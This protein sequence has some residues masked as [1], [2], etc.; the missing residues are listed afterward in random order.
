MKLTVKGE[1]RGKQRPRFNMRTGSTYTPSETVAY[2]KAIRAAYYEAGGNE[3][4]KCHGAAALLIKAYYGIPKTAPKSAKDMMLQGLRKPNK[5]PDID[6]VIKIVMDGLSGTA[7]DDDKQ[8]VEVTAA[9][10]YSDEPRIEVWINEV[11][12]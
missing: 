6:N 8:V 2:E 1:P 10:A 11:D 4:T 9:K 12:G 7:Y 5:K 3:D